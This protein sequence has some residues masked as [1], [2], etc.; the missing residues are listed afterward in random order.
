MFLDILVFLLVLSVVVLIHEAGHFLVARLIGV[1]VEEFGIG[2]PP[3]AKK[4]FSWQG[5][6]FSLNFLPIGGFVRLRGEEA[7]PLVMGEDVFF[8]KPAWK[9][10]GVLVAGVIGNFILGVILFAVV[11]SFLGIPTETEKVRIVEVSSNS[12]AEQA[13]II[14]DEIVVAVG[15]EKVTSIDQFIALIDK[16]KGQELALKLMDNEGE[17]REIEVV[18]RLE[19]PQGEG[20]LGI[21]LSNIELIKYP[22][23]QMPLRGA[24]VGVKEAVAWGGEIVAGL[25]KMVMSLITGAGVPA[26]LAG[27]IGIYQVSSRVYKFGILPFLQFVAVLSINLAIL[28]ILPF[29]AL[30]GGRIVFL[31]LEKI[32]GESFRDRFEKV[33]HV[34][35]MVILLILMVLITV[36][37]VLRLF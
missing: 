2:L 28:N 27:P 33:I 15:E 29:P 6:L 26:D 35:G 34:W 13:G 31:G 1:T 10:F 25:G 22:V 21:A 7:D 3:R 4:L 8:R 17:Y 24:V 9:R 14:L 5:T 32:F 37:D 18:P 19:A 23:W 20:A 36:R 30:D 11:Y 16:N 12:P